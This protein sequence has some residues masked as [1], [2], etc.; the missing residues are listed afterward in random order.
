M[1]LIC[2]IV[3]MAVVVSL[4]WPQQLSAQTPFRYKGYVKELGAFSLSN[5]AGT[6]RFDNIVHHR[7]ETSW[8]IG[9]GYSLRADVRNRWISGYTAR[10]LPEYGS[11]I[12]TDP[13]A[14]DLSHNWIDRRGHIVNSSVDRLHGSWEG[15]SWEVHVG[16]QRLNWGKAMVWNPNDLFNTFSWLDFDYEERPGTDAVR[17][18]HNW[19]FVSSVELGYKIARDF[20]ESVLAGMWR[21]NVGTYDIQGIA[22]YYAGSWVLGGGWSGYV[23]MSGFRGEASLFMPDGTITASVGGDHML[24]NGVYLSGEML[25]NGGFSEQPGSEADLFQPPRADHL[26]IAKTGY[27]VNVST[28]P[29]PLVTAG[30]GLMGSLTRSVHILIPQVSY[31]VA[32]NLDFLVLAQLLRGN[33]LKGLTETP[34]GVYVRLKWSY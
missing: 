31:S 10:N 16:R 17:I 21:G 32:E 7:L 23:E 22:G 24:S 29:H 12:S 2:Y 26:F 19:G 13:G 34:N 5:D 9:S 18:Q 4:Y 6:V 3:V 25:Y 15:S 1:K 14:V 20:D 28:S 8:Q 30:V 33:S 27:F 11:L